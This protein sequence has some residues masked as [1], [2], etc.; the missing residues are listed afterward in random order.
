MHTV[1]PALYSLLFAALCDTTNCCTG[2]VSKLAA[3]S[4]QI[5]WELCA[6]G[7]KSD[8][9]CWGIPKFLK[10]SCSALG[11]EQVTRLFESFLLVMWR[12]LSSF[13]G[14]INPGEP[15]HACEHPLHWNCFNTISHFA[16][17]RRSFEF[18]PLEGKGTGWAFKVDVIHCEYLCK[19]S[20]QGQSCHEN[21][22]IC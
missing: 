8:Q 19:L 4:S 14:S 22:R 9:I 7:V 13:Q 18:G 16:S 3:D 10:C 2:E 15:I 5:L 12:M 6:L 21:G 20:L 11:E 1:H 17:Y